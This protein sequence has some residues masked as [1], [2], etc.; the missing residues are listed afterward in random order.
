MNSTLIGATHFEDFQYISYGDAF[1]MHSFEVN[2]A[3]N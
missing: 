1:S 3:T 2:K